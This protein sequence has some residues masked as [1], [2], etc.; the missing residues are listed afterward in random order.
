MAE[1]VYNIHQVEETTSTNEVCMLLGQDGEKEHYVLVAE[2][3]TEGRGRLGRN[4]ES[5]KG[6]GIYMSILE[7]P[8]LSPDKSP[9]LSIVMGLA[10]RTAIEET[11]GMQCQLKWPN[12]LVFHGK[13]VS[14]ILAQMK[15]KNADRVDFIVIGIGVN[16]FQQAFDAELREK[17]TS[18]FLEGYCKAEE[19]EL[20]A[21]LIQKLVTCWKKYYLEFLKTGDLSDFLNEYHRYLANK[22]QVVRVHDSQGEYTGIAEGINSVG[23]LLVRTEN[24]IRYVNSGEVSVRGVYGYVG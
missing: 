7:R 18:L 15:V 5:E 16:L 24:E 8:N 14:G 22:D 3:Q 6:K 13:K 23:E 19:K 4:W 1:A 10:A 17:A 12:D 20:K 9:M 11:T 2:S 21:K